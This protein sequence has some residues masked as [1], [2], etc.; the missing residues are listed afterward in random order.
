MMKK[1][2]HVM[3]FDYGGTRQSAMSRYMFFFLQF[4]IFHQ[5]FMKYSTN[6]RENVLYVI[7]RMILR[8]SILGMHFFV[9]C[10]I[11]IMTLIFCLVNAIALWFQ[12]QIS[13]KLCRRQLVM[14]K[15]DIILQKKQKYNVKYMLYLVLGRK[16]ELGSE[17]LAF[18]LRLNIG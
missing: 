17:S 4:F 18:L 6:S 8:I 10:F 2:C 9:Q 12:L 5:F 11:C 3:D 1:K 7:L 13:S 16:R 15:I 14:H